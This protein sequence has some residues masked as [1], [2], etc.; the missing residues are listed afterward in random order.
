M[1]ASSGPLE[2]ARLAI[3]AAWELTLTRTATIAV[4]QA[5]PSARVQR[6]SA[7]TLA[8]QGGGRMRLSRRV[9]LERLLGRADI[10]SLHLV[11]AFDDGP[12]PFTAA[13]RHKLEGI[14]SK[15]RDAPYRSGE[16][17]HW[18][19]V[20]T[21]AWREANRGRWELFQKKR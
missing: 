4:R 2:G 10:P 20:K 14:V 13:E 18:V 11:E 6:R 5:I 1:S 15:R 21:A 19:K 3:D 8:K 16:C 12:A 17:R 7:R 9:R